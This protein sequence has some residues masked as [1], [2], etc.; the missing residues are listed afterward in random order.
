MNWEAI[1]A[2]GE[3]LGATAVLVTH[4]LREA[5]ELADRLVLLTP[6]PASVLADIGIDVPRDQRSQDAIEALRAK[7]VRSYPAQL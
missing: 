5:I 4:N 6:A 1:A 3:I 2:I 7:L